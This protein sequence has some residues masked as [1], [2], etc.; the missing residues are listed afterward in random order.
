MVSGRLFRVQVGACAR[1]ALKASPNPPNRVVGALE[2]D[3]TGIE[4]GSS[5]LI[6][7]GWRR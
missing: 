3:V 6:S 2:G 4:T 1:L 7:G 5:S